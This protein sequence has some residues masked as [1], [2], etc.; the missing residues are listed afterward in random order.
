M[1][2]RFDCQRAGSRRPAAKKPAPQPSAFIRP[3]ACRRGA[4][5]CTSSPCPG[6]SKNSL[7]RRGGPSQA[8]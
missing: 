5:D 3:C 8:M 2:G 1:S 7:S 6:S 4:Y